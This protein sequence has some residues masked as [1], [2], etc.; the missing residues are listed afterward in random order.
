MVRWRV[1]RALNFVATLMVVLSGLAIYP[2]PQASSAADLEPETIKPWHELTAD[3]QYSAG[4]SMRFYR[5]KAENGS[6]MA[7]IVLDLSDVSFSL[8]PFFV[9]KNTTT[10]DLANKRKSLAAVNGGFFNLSNGE[11]TSY[12][13]IDGKSQCEPKQNKALIENQQLKPFMETILNRSELRILEN[14][15]GK[16]KAF[17]A[18]HSAAIPAD[19]KLVHSIQAG[20][21]LLPE[22]TAEEEAFVR[23][24]DDGKIIDSIGVYKRAARTACGITPDNHILLLCVANKGQQEFS[25][26]VTLSE[27]AKLMQE[28]GS[29]SAINFDG[30]TSTTMVVAEGNYRD[31]ESYRANKV[32]SC[33]PEKLVKS[34]LIILKTAHMSRVKEQ[35][36]YQLP[37]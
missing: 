27:L 30:G 19:W 6:Q 34:G 1:Q 13:V 2:N 26:G 17:I 36:T 7:L 32:I 16:R 23:K 11:S 12:V 4:Q 31:E 25:S 24:S 5:L 8:L 21:A 37:R 18:R 35:S 9:Q 3:P 22:I 20:P 14:K 10:S 29:T 28:L 33:N 15:A